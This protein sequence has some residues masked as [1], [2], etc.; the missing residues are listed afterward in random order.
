MIRRFLILF[1]TIGMSLICCRDS[2]GQFQGSLILSEDF[3]DTIFPK[4]GWLIDAVTRITS[5]GSYVSPPAAVNYASYNGS[6]TLPV[7]GFPSIVRFQLGRTTS[8]TAKL[9]I[10]EVSTNGDP[11]SFTPVDTFSHDNTTANTFTLCET[12]L[13][14]F[15]H[16][17]AVWIRFRKSSTTTSPWRI[18]D[19][20]VYTISSLPVTLVGFEAALL[21]NGYVDLQWSTASEQH[22]QYFEIERG[23]DPV[24]F[25]VIGRVPG[26]GNSGSVMHYR[27]TDNNPYSPLCYYR[28]KQADYDG[29][30]TLLPVIQVMGKTA[31]PLTITSVISRLESI[32]VEIE[33]SKEDYVNLQIADCNGKIHHSGRYVV[34]GKNKIYI[35]RKLS[36]GIYVLLVSDL[37]YRFTRKFSVDF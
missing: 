13:S 23:R 32:V 26:G 10:V 18:D 27:F 19:I 17:A 30:V 21:P 6:L 31:G 4:P 5:S 22:N 37:Y 16:L 33:N 15:T 29:T 2:F 7:T 36:P 34:N 8:A 14:A 3:T 20:E 11:S 25:T 28:L 35:N 9:M 24:G 1:L 12:D